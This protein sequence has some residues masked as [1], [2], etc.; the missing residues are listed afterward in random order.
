MPLS[1]R[2]AR[3]DSQPPRRGLARTTIVAVTAAGA[4][5]LAAAPAFAHVTVNPRTAT[6]GGYSQLTFR[7]PNEEAKASF[8]KLTVHL[9]ADHPL[10]SV[11]TRPLPGWTVATTTAKLPKPITTDD[12]TTTDYTN[13]ITWTATDGGVAPEQYQNFDVSVGPLPDSGT[14]S[15]KADQYY[16]DGS[17]VHWDQT[18]EPGAA[19]PEKPAPVLTLTAADA[20]DQAG[21][22]DSSTVALGLSIAA[23][24][25]ALLTAG[26]SLLRRKKA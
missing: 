1:T 25:I 24:V 8:T 15:F 10:G 17:V 20:T 2:A 9:P 11:G 14:M 18:A 12:G 3:S 6:G 16:S 7:A 26:A 23:L 22:S 19:E 4:V 13:T 5:A 21:S